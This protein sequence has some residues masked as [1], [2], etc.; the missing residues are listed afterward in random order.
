M[1]DWDC[2]QLHH[3][4]PNFQRMNFHLLE[5]NHLQNHATNRLNVMQKALFYRE[6]NYSSEELSTM[7]VST[8]ACKTKILRIFLQD[9]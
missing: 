5:N 6:H 2:I 7:F 8:R 9:N 4:H 3:L 1:R